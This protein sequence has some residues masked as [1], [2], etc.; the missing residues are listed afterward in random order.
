MLNASFICWNHRNICVIPEIALYYDGSGQHLLLGFAPLRE[1]I[2]AQGFHP[3]E[4]GVVR[5]RWG[6]TPPPASTNARA[7]KSAQPSPAWGEGATR[8]ACG[9]GFWR[10]FAVAAPSVSRSGCHLPVP[11][12]NYFAFANIGA[13]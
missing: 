4:R 2:L 13:R 3:H 12:R 8:I 1:I 11:G 5:G 7:R 6:G 9:R 10:G